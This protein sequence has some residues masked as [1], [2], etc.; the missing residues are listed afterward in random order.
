MNQVIKTKM[1]GHELVRNFLQNT[2][3]WLSPISY[4]PYTFQSRA[5]FWLGMVLAAH[6]P[7]LF[8]EVTLEDG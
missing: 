7:S 5:A 4:K 6:I 1:C 3:K 8:G 2:S